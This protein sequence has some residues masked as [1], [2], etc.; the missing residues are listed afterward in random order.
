[1]DHTWL[2]HTQQPHSLVLVSSTR[3]Y[4]V[5]NDSITKNILI[6]IEKTKIKSWHSLK[7]DNGRDPEDEKE[8][9]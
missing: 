8:V 7:L 9:V 2:M 6:D 5:H 1:M 3:V 4:V